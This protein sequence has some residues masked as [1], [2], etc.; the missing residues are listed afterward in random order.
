MSPVTRRSI[1]AGASAALLAPRLAQAQHA[2]LQVFAHR[3]HK[4]VAVGSQG[5]DVTAAWTKQT[6][7]PV[8]WTTFDTGPLQ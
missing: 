2:P 4:T 5:G 7:T 3:V 6:N 1:L 8:E